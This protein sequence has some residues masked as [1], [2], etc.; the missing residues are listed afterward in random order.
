MVDIRQDWIDQMEEAE[1]QYF[2]I[3]VKDLLTTLD[4][5]EAVLFSDMLE[6]YNE[7]RLGKGKPEQK[8]WVLNRADYNIDSYEDLR[9]ELKMR[10]LL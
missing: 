5:S 4:P 9:N 3:K 6:A 2:V 10:E 8:Y 1:L 7:S